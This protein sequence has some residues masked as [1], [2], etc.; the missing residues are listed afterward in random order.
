L[1]GDGSISFKIKSVTNDNPTSKLDQIYS[2]VM[3][4]SDKS[5]SSK[6]VGIAL[7]HLFDVSEPTRFSKFVYRTKDLNA[8]NFDVIKNSMLGN[9]Y[10]GYVK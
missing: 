10:Y 7:K 8:P 4:S 3:V 1:T 9:S 2:F 6:M 5:M